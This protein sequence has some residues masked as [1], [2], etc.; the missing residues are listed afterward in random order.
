MSAGVT[1]RA[2]HGGIFVF[3]AMTNVLMFLLALVVG[4]LVGAA[5]VVAA[6]QIG[7]SDAE[8]ASAATAA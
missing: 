7:R 8:V 2:P 3:F 4:T 5:A 6:K 1:L